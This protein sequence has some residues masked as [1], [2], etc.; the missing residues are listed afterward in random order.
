VLFLFLHIFLW[1]SRWNARHASLIDCRGAIIVDHLRFLD[2]AV[3]VRGLD[4]RRSNVHATSFGV[5]WKKLLEGGVILQE[6][7][8]LKYHFGA[9]PGDATVA[10]VNV[11]LENSF[12]DCFL[13]R[14]RLNCVDQDAEGIHGGGFSEDLVGEGT[15]LVVVLV[16]ALEN[17]F[18]NHIEE[19]QAVD[20][21]HL[22]RRLLGFCLK[23][24][25]LQMVDGRGDCVSG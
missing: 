23:G 20:R 6:A 11:V 25:K 9:R 24:E 7:H 14:S 1:G 15:V 3:R 17:G 18:T 10:E 5:L 12:E 16:N 2:R 21:C 8:G 22:D 19:V 4:H 13:A